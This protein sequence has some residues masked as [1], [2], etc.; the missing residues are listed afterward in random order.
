[1]LN[2]TQAVIEEL[3]GISAVAR[4]MGRKYDAVWVWRK[5]NRFPA[6]TFLAIRA[7]LA[8]RGKSAPPELWGM[9]DA[10]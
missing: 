2:S 4:A 6:H 1:M 3:G 5:T 8:E 7:L 10:A 9:A